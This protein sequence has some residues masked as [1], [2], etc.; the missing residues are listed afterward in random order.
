MVHDTSLVVIGLL[1]QEMNSP[2]EF[3]L[4]ARKENNKQKSD[5][6]ILVPAQR[7]QGLLLNF[8]C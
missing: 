2:T 5:G 4:F 3:N 8:S 7:R 6:T 1:V